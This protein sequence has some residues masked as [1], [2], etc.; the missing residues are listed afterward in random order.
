MTRQSTSVIKVCVAYMGIQVLRQL[1]EELT[2]ATDK[3]LQII[4]NV[5][6][7][8]TTMPL[9]IKEQNYFK[10]K[11]YNCICYYVVLSKII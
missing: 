2:R 1:K 6:L 8:K 9:R 10:F 7:F 11:E 4:S 3:R 5:M